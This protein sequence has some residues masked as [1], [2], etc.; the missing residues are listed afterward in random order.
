MCSRLTDAHV[1]LC[2]TTVFGRAAVMRKTR[3]ILSSAR[4]D[5]RLALAVPKAE[6]TPASPPRELICILGGLHQKVVVTLKLIPNH[7]S[8][9]D[10]L[11]TVHAMRCRLIQAKIDFAMLNARLVKPRSRTLCW[12]KGANYFPV[13][14]LS[15]LLD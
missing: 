3:E 11:L 6:I 13:P 5:S 14:Q 1:A 12:L 7:L 2:I 8:T 15:G 10:M 9:M 4:E